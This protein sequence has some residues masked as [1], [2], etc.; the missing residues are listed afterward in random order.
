MVSMQAVEQERQIRRVWMVT[1]E[2]DQLAGAGGVKDVCRQ[3]AEALVVHGGCVV[4]A[5]LPRYGFMD[6]ERLGC[7]LLPIGQASGRIGTGHSAR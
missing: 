6:V 2:Y 1:R 7:R 3:L 5:V 4:R